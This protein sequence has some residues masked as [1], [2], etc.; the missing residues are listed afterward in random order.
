M[1][2]TCPRCGMT[3]QNPTDEAEG[4]CGNC[5][6]VT[7]GEKAKWLTSG[8]TVI[9]LSLY[10]DNDVKVNIGGSYVPVT[11]VWYDRMADVIVLE[12]AKGVDL[13][14]ALECAHNNPDAHVYL[15]TGC[16]HDEHDYCKARN[17]AAGPKKPG[18]CKFCGAPCVCECHR[19]A[20]S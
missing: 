6:E 11:E 1:S 12:P 4:Y 14:V 5:H 3:S 17:G 19:G 2:F 20:C 7:G 16:L 9:A 13:E 18:Q 8:M 15:S 10:R